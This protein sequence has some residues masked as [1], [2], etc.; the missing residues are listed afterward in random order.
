MANTAFA[1]WRVSGIWPTLKTNRSKAGTKSC[2]S[3][4][5]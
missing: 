3:K 1:E 4:Q 2:R 5:R